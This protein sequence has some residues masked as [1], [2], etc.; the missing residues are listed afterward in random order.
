MVHTSHSSD[1]VVGDRLG[2]RVFGLV[3]FTKRQWMIN[4]ELKTANDV[5]DV[6]HG[7]ARLVGAIDL[8]SLLRVVERNITNLL[9]LHLPDL[10]IWV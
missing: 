5:E 4:K 9:P 10:Q 6:E 2:K 1:P 7:V 3:R 8:P